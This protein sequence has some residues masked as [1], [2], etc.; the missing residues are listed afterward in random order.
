MHYELI[1]YIYCINLV[2]KHSKIA[3]KLRKISTILQACDNIE[4]SAIFNVKIIF[5]TFRTI[6]DH[7]DHLLVLLV[8]EIK[9]Q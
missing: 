3:W 2:L 8:K 7:I 6:W 5:L 9:R 4:M 1:H